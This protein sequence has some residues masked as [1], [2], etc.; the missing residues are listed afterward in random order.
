[1]IPG[2]ES[3]EEGCCVAALG[4]RGET[5]GQLD[6]IIYFRSISVGW[7]DEEECP[8]NSKERCSNSKD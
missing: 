2:S 1:M 8:D 4:N 6:N 5:N 7:I 3:V